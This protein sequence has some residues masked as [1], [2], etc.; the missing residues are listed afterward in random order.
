MTLEHNT[1]QRLIGLHALGDLSAKEAEFVTVHAQHCPS[2]RRELFE[3]SR[4]AEQLGGMFAETSCRLPPGFSESLI[5]WARQAKS[6]QQ[7]NR[8]IWVRW[9]LIPIV[10][11]ILFVPVTWLQGAIFPV[12]FAVTGFA[13]QWLSVAIAGFFLGLLGFATTILAARLLAR[14]TA[15]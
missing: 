9:W 1:A 3:L 5:H 7:E 10:E 12:G 8:K 13:S 4:L 15:A 11:T 14:R 6:V 2:C